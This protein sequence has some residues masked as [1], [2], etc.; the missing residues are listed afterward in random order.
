MRKES[1]KAEKE[2]PN[3]RVLKDLLGDHLE[4]KMIKYPPERQEVACSIS[5]RTVTTSR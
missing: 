5:N 3:Q 4:R 1:F 2:L